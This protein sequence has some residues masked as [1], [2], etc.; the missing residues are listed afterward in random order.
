VEL[1]EDRAG[2]ARSGTPTRTLES[3]VMRLATMPVSFGLQFGFK[4]ELSTPRHMMAVILVIL[5]YTSNNELE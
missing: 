3:R 4:Y 5:N 2:V 1:H